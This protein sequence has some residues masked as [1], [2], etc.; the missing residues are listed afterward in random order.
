MLRDALPKIITS[1]LPGPRASDIIRRREAA[2]PSAIRCGYP[3]VIHRGE[4]AMVEDVDGNIFLDWVGG[5]GVLNVGYS[6][7]EMIN[8]VKEQADRYFHAMM[9]IAT[10]E[11]YI[12]LAEKMNRIVPVRGDIRRTM[13]VNSGAE[14][15]EN[16]VKIAK[17]YTKR[18]NIIVFSGAFHGRTT[19]TMAMT[20]K[21]AYSA[22][23]GPFP[24]GIYRAEFPYLYR[25]PKGFGNKEAIE[26]YVNKLEKVFD[27][28]TPSEYVAAII[29]EP[30]QGEGGF[31]P[32]PIEW[33]K[34]VR[35]ICDEH[36]ILIIADEVQ[37]GFGRS[38][39]W[40]VSDYWAQAGCAPDII[41]TAK[42]IAGGVPLSA[43]TAR[44]EIFA[45]VRPGTIGGTYSGNPLACS[46]ALKV[47]DIIERDNLCD[48]AMKISA[49]CM[50]RFGSWKERYEEVGDVRGI[51]A[52]L[53][54]EF[55]RDKES[56]EPNGEIVSRL[57]SE[58]AANGLI[59]EGA[60]TYGNVVRFL[61]PL[62]VTDAQLEAGFDILENAI[63]KCRKV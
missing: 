59:I 58:C 43:V 60:G 2:I 46:S 28:C 22:G 27:E 31:I 19:L 23:M 49:M 12:S 15:D 21:K 25:K 3:L 17:A 51:G 45:A 53:G 41:T 39:R 14:A 34:E 26:Y 36:G 54:I 57:V 42:S 30:I 29:V 13:F 38:G 18:P 8:A 1:A 20:A 55:V 44:T 50:D 40:F 10:H 9:N 16:A 61:C 33:V 32:A 4:G 52:M 47:I 6:Q 11:G 35:R 48:R 62:V 63:E 24:D 5:V 7:P 37:C 56:M